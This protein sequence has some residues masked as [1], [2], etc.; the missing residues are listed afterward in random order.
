MVRQIEAG[1]E[2][3]PLCA[4]A[5]L[6][7]RP[8]HPIDAYFDKVL[9][10][11]EDPAVRENRLAFLAATYSLFGALCG[12]PKTGRNR[13]TCPLVAAS[14]RRRNRSPFSARPEITE[15]FPGSTH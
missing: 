15:T 13:R 2:D 6:A 1:R 3:N 10:N 7:L 9:V 14:S 12:L 5:Q 11:S 4:G 8:G